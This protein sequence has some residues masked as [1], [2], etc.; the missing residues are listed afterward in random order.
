[1]AHIDSQ[2]DTGKP[3][4]INIRVC[5]DAVRQRRIVT[6][7]PGKEEKPFTKSAIQSRNKTKGTRRPLFLDSCIKRSIRLDPVVLNHL[8]PDINLLVDENTG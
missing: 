6:S 3:T 5:P 4:F 2:K 7:S 8:R 1:M